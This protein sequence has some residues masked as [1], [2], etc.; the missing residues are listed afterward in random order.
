[1]KRAFEFS[2]ARLRGVSKPGRFLVLSLADIPQEKQGAAHGQTTVSRFGLIATKRIGCAVERNRAR[3][4]V[5]ELIRAHGDPVG[6][7]LYVV[8]ILRKGAITASPEEL[9]KDYIKCQ[10]KVL[11]AYATAKAKAK[12]GAPVPS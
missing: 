11:R 12:G 10:A 4:R 3:R 1:M 7:G 5:R 6:K 9:E 8:V 2:H